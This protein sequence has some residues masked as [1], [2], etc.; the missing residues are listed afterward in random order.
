VPRRGVRW[1]K[2]LARPLQVL[3]TG[4]LLV[5]GAWGYQELGPWAGYTVGALL[6]LT[7]LLPRVLRLFRRP[8]PLRRLLD[9][10]PYAFE[11]LVGEL[12]RRLRFQR[13]EVV[14]RTG[15]GGVDLTA[16]LNG[17]RILVQCKRYA[18]GHRVTVSQVREFYGVIRQRGAVHG[19]LVTTSRF[20]RPALE[21]A[22]E[23]SVFRYLTLWDGGEVL[24]RLRRHRLYP[25]GPLPPAVRAVQEAREQAQAG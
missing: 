24:R 18:P 10:D 9:L 19:Y 11:A 13:V 7:L 20:T 14:G 3:W 15:D 23:A 12:F 8:S 22:R 1:R 17:R 6:A 4:G 25:Y 5:G 21:F 2:R 16:S